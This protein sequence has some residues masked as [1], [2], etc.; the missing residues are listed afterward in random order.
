MQ[1]ATTEAEI[2][3]AVLPE[4][5]LKAEFTQ[6]EW[7]AAFA[8]DPNGRKAPTNT[9]TRDSVYSPWTLLKPIIYV[10]PVQFAVNVAAGDPIR[11][12]MHSNQSP[13]AQTQNS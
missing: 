11:G 10:D 7:A 2:T 4:A 13:P 12:Q 3:I 6:P 1:Q 5:Y 8:Q 9:R